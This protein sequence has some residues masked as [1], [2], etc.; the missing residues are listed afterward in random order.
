MKTGRRERA[1]AI[2]KA[3]QRERRFMRR[4]GWLLRHW[5]YWPTI[6]ILP[7][8]VQTKKTPIRIA[9]F[10]KAAAQTPPLRATRQLSMRLM[11]PDYQGLRENDA[12]L[13]MQPTS[14][15]CDMV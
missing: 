15:Y 14:F 13:L 5:L 9:T 2:I 3:H 10:Q 7:M 8:A 11:S 6:L 4:Q 12:Y 1:P